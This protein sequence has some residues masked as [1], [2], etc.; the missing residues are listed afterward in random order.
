MGDGTSIEIPRTAV[1]VVLRPLANA[2]QDTAPADRDRQLD[3]A[4]ARRQGDAPRGTS[5]GRG[6]VCS[7]PTGRSRS[8]RRASASLDDTR[9]EE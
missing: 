5:A 1:D 7:L 2:R 8:A 4:L 9:R 6:P 3:G